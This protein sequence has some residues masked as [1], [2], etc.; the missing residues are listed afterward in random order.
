MFLLKRII[1]YIK[2]VDDPKSNTLISEHGI[3]R[4][5]QPNQQMQIT[6][7]LLS[8]PNRTGT[9]Q[10]G[11]LPNQFN[12]SQV[13]L[14]NST[15][16][17]R[18]PNSLTYKDERAN[19]ISQQNVEYNQFNQQNIQYNQQNVLNIDSIQKLGNIDN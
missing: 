4:S 15:L 3:Q 14:G 6:K 1:I 11:S 2:E 12:N 9:K 7:N 13:S 5:N 17:A 19:F 10:I 18:N 16:S 8:S